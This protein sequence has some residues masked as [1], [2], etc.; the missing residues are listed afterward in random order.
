MATRPPSRHRPSKRLSSEGIN[1]FNALQGYFSE[2][3]A[4][5]KPENQLLRYLEPEFLDQPVQWTKNGA[6]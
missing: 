6:D 3:K 2:A 1:S 5:I 4:S